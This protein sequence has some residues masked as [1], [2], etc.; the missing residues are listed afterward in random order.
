[1]NSIANKATAVTPSNTN[2]ITDSVSVVSLEGEKVF[3]SVN[4]TAE[5]IT[6]VNHGYNTNDVVVVKHNGTTDLSKTTPYFVIR[7]SADV[8]QLS[9]SFNGTA[10]NIGG[11]NTTAP[12]L[13]I[14]NRLQTVRVEGCISVV[15]AGD[16][17]VLPADHPDTNTAT[18][19]TN[20]AIRYTLAAGQFLPI[21][22][23]KVFA[24]GTTATGIVCSYGQ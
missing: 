17:V 19:A 10:V 12:T 23:K 2:Y 15:G 4:I 20:G 8:I 22:V 5:T 21:V 3:T 18:L 9:L 7:T 24:T 14:I 6:L 13:A 1:M 16:V 11:A